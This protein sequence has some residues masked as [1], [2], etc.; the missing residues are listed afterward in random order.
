MKLYLDSDGWDAMRRDLRQT[1]SMLRASA[2]HAP[3]A[4]HLDKLLQRW[5]ALDVQRR[6][7]AD[8]VSDAHAQVAWLDL[9]LDAVT[10]RLVGQLV[11]ECNND[12]GHPTFRAFFPDAPSEVLRLA[13][14][15]QLDA[16]K[17]FGAAAS[18]SKV[19]KAVTALVAEIAAI[20]EDAR[21]ALSAR[22]D[23]VVRTTESSLAVRSWRDDAN[24][25]RRSV[26]T[27]L[28]DHANKNALAR[29]YRDRFFAAT[30]GSARK[31]RPGDAPAPTD[32]PSP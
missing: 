11:A 14:E 27:A 26:A 1:R 8:E 4:R 3:L 13:L 5:D 16:S 19:S 30:R 29:D 17:H 7:A 9:R 28:D 25:A 23:A 24:A 20:E 10:N 2:V 18:A 12:R 6:S 22:R 21:A 15:S 31:R 32:P